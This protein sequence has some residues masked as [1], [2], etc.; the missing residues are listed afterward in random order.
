M[1]HERIQQ[2]EATLEDVPHL[3]AETR[4]SLQRLLAELKAEIA[5]LLDADEVAALQIADAAGDS[6]VAATRTEPQPQTAQQ[7]IQNLSAS[8]EGFEASHPNLVHVVNRI[9]VTLGNMGI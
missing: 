2:I 9:A 1:I 7:A 6:V 8:V 3:P 4:E 5:P